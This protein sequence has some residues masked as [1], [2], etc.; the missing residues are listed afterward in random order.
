MLF[1]VG[2]TGADV[3]AAGVMDPSAAP[4]IYFEKI[5]KNCLDRLLQALFGTFCTIQ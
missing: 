3:R 1:A 2:V 4:M 5:F